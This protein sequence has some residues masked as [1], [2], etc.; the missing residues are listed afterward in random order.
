[1]TKICIAIFFLA[2]FCFISQSLVA[3]TSDVSIRLD[4]KWKFKLGENSEYLSP[5]QNDAAWPDITVPAFWQSQ[6]YAQAGLALYR[7]KVF[8][9]KQAKGKDKYLAL[10]KISDI[11]EVYFNGVLIGRT[12]NIMEPAYGDER[13]YF[14][15]DSL[16]RYDAQNLVAVRVLDLGKQDAAYVSGSG[17]YEGL[18]KDK[19]AIGIFSRKPLR[20]MKGL[21]TKPASAE[22][23]K[24]VRSVIE[25]MDKALLSEDLL[26]YIINLSESYNNNGTAYDE[27]KKFAEGLTKGLKGVTKIVYPE[28]DIYEITPTK[29]VAVYS[30]DGYKGSTLFYRG[31]D[32]R[33]F[34]KEGKEWKE[35]GNQSRYFEM[36]IRSRYMGMKMPLTVY[37]PPS[38]LKSAPDK[39]Y[40]VLY[41]LH[42]SGGSNRSWEYDHVK[43]ILDEQMTSGKIAEMI[44]V[45]PDAHSTFYVN[46][47]DGKRPFENYF[48]YELPTIIDGDYRTIDSRAARGIDGVSL[49]GFAAYMLALKTERG[50]SLFGSVGSMMGMLG[51][52]LKNEPQADGG[53]KEFW[54]D[55]VTTKIMQDLPADTLKKFHFQFIVGRSDSLAKGNIETSRLL[56]EKKVPH[57]F[58]M[59]DGKHEKDFWLSHFK[60]ELIFHSDSFQSALKK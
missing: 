7:K 60:E 29:V 57:I 27:Q 1:M 55:Y 23:A 8:I 44:V 12:G 41:L 58:R 36:E 13:E 16:I 56:R 21:P 17:I 49:G 47:A 43:D 5:K 35:I 51:Y 40:P 6:G 42:G 9:P 31:A 37:L 33:Y 50:R 4:G 45:M 48:L 14:I 19:Q 59:T 24:Q 53:K 39:R 28:F 32:E 3:Q 10:G 20:Q 22:T 54:A 2:G 30:S 46:S 26:P 11:D 15:P 34:A 52:E 38:Y 18:G 25:T